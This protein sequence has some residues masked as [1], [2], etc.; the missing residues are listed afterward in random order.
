M[1]SFAGKGAGTT[2]GAGLISSF[3]STRTGAG[4]GVGSGLISSFFSAKAAGAGAGTTTGGAACE[5]LRDLIF[6]A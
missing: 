5:M 2:T 3:F 4:S 1:R 6:F